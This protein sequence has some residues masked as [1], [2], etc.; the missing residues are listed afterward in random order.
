MFKGPILYYFNIHSRC[1][2]CIHTESIT[3][4]PPQRNTH[5]CKR[6]EMSRQDFC[7]VTTIQSLVEVCEVNAATDSVETVDDGK[8]LTNQSRLIFCGRGS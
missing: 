1:R 6:F 3:T 4:L 5:S 7:D 2:I 8:T